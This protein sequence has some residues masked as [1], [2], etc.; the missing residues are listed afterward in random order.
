M[1]F[2]HL[3]KL[4]ADALLMIIR[5]NQHVMQVGGHI[6]DNN[7]TICKSPALFRLLILPKLDGDVCQFL[8]HD[9]PASLYLRPGAKGGI[10]LINHHVGW[11]SNGIVLTVIKMPS[12]RNQFVCIYAWLIEPLIDFRINLVEVEIP[13]PRCFRRIK[14]FLIVIAGLPT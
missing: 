7:P 1:L 4:V 5:T 10:V 6:T 11:R 3:K 14:I 13:P 12:R 2:H 8:R 9:I